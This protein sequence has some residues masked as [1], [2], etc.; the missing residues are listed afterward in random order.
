MWKG[1]G[2]IYSAILVHPFLTGLTDGSLPHG[3]FAFYVIQDALY[4]RQYAQALAAVAS[5]APDAA[6]TEMFA[7]HAADAVAVERALHGSLLADL[8]IEPASADV[9]E[10]A[11]TTLAYTSYLLAAIHGGSYATGSA[12][13][14]RATGST[15]RS[16]RSC[17]AVV[18]P[19]R[20][21]SGGS[22]CTAARSSA[23]LSARCFPWPMRW[24]RAWRR[25]NARA[26]IGTSG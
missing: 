25:V 20:V 9:A 14:C 16:A 6:G 21:I 10:A 13:S 3:T 26:S 2:D 5:R 15:G 11:P 7:R 23:R 19:T 8:G 18:H 12:R 1:I 4:L 22:I 24:A 17:C